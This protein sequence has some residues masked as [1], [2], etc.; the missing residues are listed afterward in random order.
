M[1]DSVYTQQDV[2]SGASDFAMIQFL[3]S[4]ALKRIPGALPV[5]VMSCTNDG[6]L[7][8]VGT[9]NV[10]PLV[11]QMDGN[12]QVVPGGV[13]TIYQLPYMRLQGG[14]SA[15]ILDPAQGDIGLCH[16]CS[17][18]IS[19]VKA[20]KAL[21]PPGSHRT[22][23]WADGVYVGGLLNGAPIQYVQ[24]S[25]SGINIVSPTQISLNGVTIDPSGN[26]SSPATIKAATDVQAGTNNTSLVNHM[27]DVVGVEA[28]GSTL[29]TT[30]PLP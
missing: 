26:L 27:H 17:R 18:D 30:A 1:S 7:S 11:Q 12:W 25:S 15:I 5:L 13:A 10:M 14:A 9:V 23:D 22:N 6:G 21:S 16:F 2:Q 24:F 4:Q 19:I 20:T 8:P 3:I 29:P 28:G